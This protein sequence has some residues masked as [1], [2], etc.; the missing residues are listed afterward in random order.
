MILDTF[1]PLLNTFSQTFDTFSHLDTG[2]LMGNPG[3]PPGCMPF[4]SGTAL[5]FS[6]SSIEPS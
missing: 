5:S 2:W 4:C 6:Y 3:H 1:S